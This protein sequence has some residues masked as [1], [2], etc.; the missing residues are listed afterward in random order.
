MAI[1]PPYVYF[2]VFNE[3]LTKCA[4]KF[5]T[6]ANII[7]TIGTR[8]NEINCQRVAPPRK[9]KDDKIIF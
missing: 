5:T 2:V 9:W 6:E 7:K 3:K 8:V 1:A 4:T